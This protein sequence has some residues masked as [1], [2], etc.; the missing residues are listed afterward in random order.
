MVGRQGTDA[1]QRQVD[2]HLAT[3]P[4]RP[5][6]LL[7]RGGEARH[8]MGAPEVSANRQPVDLAARAV[9]ALEAPPEVC[10]EPGLVNAEAERVVLERAVAPP[11]RRAGA[12]HG[13]E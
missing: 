7:A 1:R 8:E 11:D 3:R 10:V 2:V 13:A 12:E 4:R 5:A 6:I 9:R